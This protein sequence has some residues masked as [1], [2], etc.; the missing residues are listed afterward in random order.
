MKH[1]NI[2]ELF[3]SGL[4][5]AGTEYKE[6][7]WKQMLGLLSAKDGVAFFRKEIILLALIF[8]LQIVLV[9]YPSNPSKAVVKT[10]TNEHIAD[11][12][13]SKELAADTKPTEEIQNL[14]DTKVPTAQAVESGTVKLEETQ[15]Q[16]DGITETPQESEAQQSTQEDLPKESED[17]LLEYVVYESIFTADH[18]FLESKYLDQIPYDLNNAIRMKRT[19]SFEP[20]PLMFYLDAHS[21]I[22]TYSKNLGADAPSLL[23]QDE[24]P[25]GYSNYGIDIRIQRQ[26]LSVSTGVSV[27]EWRES[28]PYKTTDPVYQV[29]S[30]LRIK[31][32]NF[33]R[34][35]SGNKVV[36]LEWQKDTVQTGLDTSY[37]KDC[38]MSLRYLTIPVKVDYEFPLGK[39]RMFAGMGMNYNFLLNANGFYTSLTEVVPLSET[40]IINRSFL[41]LNLDLGIRGEFVHGLGYFASYRYGFGLNS[42]TAPYSQTANSHQVRM[43]VSLRL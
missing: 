26:R 13:N 29:D 7:Y 2:D 6:S 3:R 10:S 28:V 38:R 25:I 14:D 24:R 1:N 39:V 22:G 43:G 8:V 20:K 37:C 4:R 11:Q 42:M 32:W 12:L 21:S 33:G 19:G 36:L 15:S 41:N 23:K 35:G 34:T 27:S 17:N 30:T 40:R 31:D 5:D 16:I 18:N 9:W